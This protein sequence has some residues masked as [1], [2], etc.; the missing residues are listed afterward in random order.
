MYYFAYGS[1]MNFKQMKIRCPKAIFIKRV[2]L[3]NYKFIYDGYSFYRKGAVANITPCNKTIVWGGLYE[4]DE[5]CLKSLDRYEGYPS[6]YDREELEVK[7]KDENKFKAWVYLREGKTKGIPSKEYREII[8]EGA[9]D[10]LL[11]NDY[12]KKFL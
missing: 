4:I 8:L 9:R 7:D 2:Y 6:A 10:C 3:E 1:N 12:I 11:P 5:E